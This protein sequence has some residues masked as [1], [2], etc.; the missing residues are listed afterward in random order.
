M[1]VKDEA[2]VIERCLA[3]VKPVIDRWVIVDTGSTDGTQ[4]I[5]R[6]VMA[7]IPGQLHERP[8]RNFGH[9]RTEALEL[10]R[11]QGDY[12]LF[13]DADE[14]LKVDSTF[15]PTQLSGD[16]YSLTTYFGNLVYDRVSLVNSRLP[17]KWC[18]VLHEYL[19]AGRAVAQP[20]LPGLGILVTPD[21]ARSN[22]PHK[23][24]K[25]A[26]VLEEALKAEPDNARYWFYLGQSYRDCGQ[27]ARALHA[28]QRRLTLGGW[29]EEVWY[30]LLQVARMKELLAAPQDEVTA[31]YLAAHER[32]PS[33]AESLVSLVIY[34]RS[35]QAW[36]NAYGYA[37]AALSIPMTTDR[38][39]VESDSY[40]WR[41]ADEYA[42]AAFYCGQTAEAARIWEGVLA[43]RSFPESEQPRLQENLQHAT[44][45]SKTHISASAQPSQDVPLKINIGCG[46]NMREGWVNVDSQRLPGVDIVTDL[47]SLGQSPLPLADN[48]ADE[49]LLSHVLEHIRNV[50]PMMQELHR[51]A[52]PHA[53]MQI[54]VPYGSSDDAFEDPTHVRQLFC[55]S[56]GYFS[57]PHY[58]RADYGYRGD[59]V[60]EKIELSISQK[61]RHLDDA[62][63]WDCIQRDRNVVTEM[64]ATLRAVKP[65]R[66]PVKELQN[67]P[68]IILLR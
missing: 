68:R 67:T 21:G 54:R 62:A 22:D 49:Y 51:I 63:L 60:T 59:W 10:A 64:V 7:D 12:L 52:R 20:R 3:S 15:D 34:L 5:I 28:Y 61:F 27:F 17:W 35:K 47:E 43:S 42:L 65:I 18:G 19:D 58:W 38:L 8:W 1:I 30:A 36:Q 56:F 9:N 4:E 23:F 25:D 24:E 13:I 39:F 16:A 29:E 37:Q 26:A 66:P 6:R 45:L 50:L 40:G 2:R 57:Q 46:R 41:R 14:Q 44:N 48:S 55:G 32:R 33:R 31:A 11:A 53:L